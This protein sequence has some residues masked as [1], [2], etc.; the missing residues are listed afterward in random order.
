MTAAKYDK[1]AVV[2]ETIGLNS[3][4]TQWKIIHL[5][6]FLNFIQTGVGE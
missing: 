1:F 2:L 3:C 4:N 5:H 6:L